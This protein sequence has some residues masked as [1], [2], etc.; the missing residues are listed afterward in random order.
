MLN[1][2]F[3]LAQK[4]SDRYETGKKYFR[5]LCSSCHSVHQEIYGPMLGSISKKKEENWL[6]QFIQNSQEV[7]RSGDPYAGELFNRFDNQ[8]MPSFEQL[9]TEDIQSILYYLEVE[10]IHP[11]EHLEDSEILSIPN[12][13]IIKG[14]QEFIEHCSSCHFIHT[15]STFAPALGSV[16]KRHSREWLI[17]FIQNSQKK[18]QKGDP[19]AQHLFNEFNEHVMTKMEFLS[20][21]EINAV[22]DYIEYASTLNVAYKGKINQIEYKKQA[23]NQINKITSTYSKITIVYF[24]FILTALLSALLLVL[25]LYVFILKLYYK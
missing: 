12:S 11:S 20:V 14:K 4:D 8:T 24:A 13:T 7:I 10:S 19:Y 2:F 25:A 16:T 3:V 5:T 9:T 23:A 21:K 17:S 1:S 18:I 15:E 6:I 22:L